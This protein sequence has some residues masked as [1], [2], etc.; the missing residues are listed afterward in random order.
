ML[1][2]APHVGQLC[3]LEEGW[4]A[5]RTLFAQMCS[6]LAFQTACRPL[7]EAPRSS[8]VSAGCMLYWWSHIGGSEAE[9]EAESVAVYMLRV[10]A[11]RDSQRLASEIKLPFVVVNSGAFCAAPAST[12]NQASTRQRADPRRRLLGVLGS[13]RRLPVVLAR[14]GRA[15][16]RFQRADSSAAPTAELRVAAS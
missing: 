1:K 6:A 11:L 14:A 4:A 5:N 2:R 15:T 7:T 12:P 13:P 10:Q 3:G 8:T 9:A 16:T